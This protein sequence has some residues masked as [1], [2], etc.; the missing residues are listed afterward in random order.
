MQ[1][2]REIPVTSDVRIGAD[3]SG[4]VDREQIR[5]LVW[6]DGEDAAVA[7]PVIGDK[8]WVVRALRAVAREWTVQEKQRPL[9]HRPEGDYLDCTAKELAVVIYNSHQV[10]VERDEIFV[11]SGLASHY[12]DIAGYRRHETDWAIDRLDDLAHRIEHEEGYQY[13]I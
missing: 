9:T 3:E 13:E 4:L 7:G 10:I 1:A 2:S 12:I 11:G 8:G 5:L 6:I